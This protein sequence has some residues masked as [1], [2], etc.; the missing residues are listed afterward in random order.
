MAME[1][2]RDLGTGTI[3]KESRWLLF[4][5]FLS[6]FFHASFFCTEEMVESKW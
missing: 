6:Y 2:I 5:F 4:F 3:I 1:S